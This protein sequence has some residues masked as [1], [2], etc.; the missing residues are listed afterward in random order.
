MLPTNHQSKCEHKQSKKFKGCEEEISFISA[1]RRGERKKSETNAILQNKSPKFV[2][3]SH[4]KQ[5]MRV[6]LIKLPLIPMNNH[7]AQDCISSIVKSNRMV[8]NAL[9]LH[10]ILVLFMI[11]THF[12]SN[13]SWLDKSIHLIN[14][15][16]GRL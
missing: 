7:M 5:R 15:K 9:I 14:S 2:E 13:E 4:T 12:A 8:E 16:L 10:L 1:N 3:N 6:Q 11:I